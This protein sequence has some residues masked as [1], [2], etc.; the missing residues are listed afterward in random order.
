M[1]FRGDR[2]RDARLAVKVRTNGK[3]GSQAWLAHTVGAHVT[4]ISD[5]ERGENE[6]SSRY[7]AKLSAAVSVSADHLL[8][9]DEDEEEQQVRDHADIL[10]A[11][12]VALESFHPRSRDALARTLAKDGAE[13]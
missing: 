11:L 9:D 3:K 10:A 8:D 6:P 7:I 4:S 12:A 1:T 2:L 5:W 13:A